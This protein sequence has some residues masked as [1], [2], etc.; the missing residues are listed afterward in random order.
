MKLRIIMAAVLISPLGLTLEASA[1]ED[2]N[3][4]TN[5]QFMRLVQSGEGSHDSNSGVAPK[6]LEVRSPS[7]LAGW[8]TP[9]YQLVSAFSIKVTEV[10]ITDTGIVLGIVIPVNN[11]L[12]GVDAKT[13]CV[14]LL[15]RAVSENTFIKYH[16]NGRIQKIG[17]IYFNYDAGNYLGKINRIGDL[18]FDY[19]IVGN[20]I[21]KFTRIGD[22]FFSY[23]QERIKGLNNAYFDYDTSGKVQTIRGDQP[24]VT[25]K[26]IP[27]QEWRN[28][29]GMPNLEERRL[30][31]REPINSPEALIYRYR[32]STF[33]ASYCSDSSGQH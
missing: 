7:V 32:A 22:L 23:D 9:G 1:M 25:V 33:L 24:G 18:N 27:L 29:L 8:V 5:T 26:I 2:F 13:N 19:E 6:S 4:N 16:P 11:L 28:L 15:P 3:P 14:N 31:N 30:R 10:Y 21:S 20:V 12:V 17:T